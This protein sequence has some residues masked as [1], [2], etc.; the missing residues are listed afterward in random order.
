MFITPTCFTFLNSSSTFFFPTT[1]L[2]PPISTYAHFF[3]AF[4]SP[5][6]LFI[7]FQLCFLHSCLYELQNFENTHNF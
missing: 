3:F 7:I 6:I 5:L 2:P 1:P 4:P